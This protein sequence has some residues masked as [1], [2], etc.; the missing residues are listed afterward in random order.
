ME[1]NKEMTAQQ[2][3]AIIAESMNNSRKAILRS[4]APYFILWG[5]LL[6]VVSLV[7]YFLWHASGHPVW[8]M[9]WFAMPVLGYA[10]AFLLRKKEGPVPTN[11]IGRLLGPIWGTFGVFSMCLS[12]IAVFFVPM[13][14]S[15]I[16]V[17]ILGLA[18]SISGVVLKNWPITVAGAILG[19]GGA[20]A[21]SLLQGAEQLFLFT[22]GGILLVLT[23]LIIK[24]QYK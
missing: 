9:L 19:I 4:S 8:N 1:Q 17:I 22:L 16:I 11:E 6:T 24:F 7:I 15:L 23:G 2:S 20:V 5:I 12:A 21:A 3:L 14:I 10:S 13:N 18:E